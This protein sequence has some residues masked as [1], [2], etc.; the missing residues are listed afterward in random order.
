VAVETNLV[1]LDDKSAHADLAAVAAAVED[2][3]R[4]ADAVDAAVREIVHR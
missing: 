2:V 4:R 3:V 1:G